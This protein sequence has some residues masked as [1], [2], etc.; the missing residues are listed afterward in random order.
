[1]FGPLK[2]YFQNVANTPRKIKSFFDDEAALFWLKFV[3]SQLGITNQYVL[4]VESK[5]AAAF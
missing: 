2:E 3:E 5:G 1:M 4:I